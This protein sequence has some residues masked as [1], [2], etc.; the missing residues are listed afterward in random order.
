[1]KI[2]LNRLQFALVIVFISL[3]STAT[4]FAEY[5]YYIPYF[6][7]SSINGEMVGLALT[8]TGNEDALVKIAVLDQDGITRTVEK[9]EISA[10]AQKAALIGRELNEIEGSFRV[11]SDQPLTGVAFLFANQMQAMT[12]LPMTQDTIT[13]LNIP[14]VAEDSEWRTKILISNPYAETVSLTL[15]YRDKN[16]WRAGVKPATGPFPN[17]KNQPGTKYSVELEAYASTVIELSEL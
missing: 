1:M 7:N 15:T 6:S 8:N 2:S 10:F 9:W 3:I 4:A 5:A 11:L 17:T 16:G 12:Y 13:K 14:H